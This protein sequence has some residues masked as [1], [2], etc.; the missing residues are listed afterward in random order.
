MNFRS[1]SG[2]FHFF[3]LVYI[4]RVCTVD[5]I[6]NIGDAVSPIVEAVL[7]QGYRISGCAII[8][9]NAVIVYNCIAGFHAFEAFEIFGH[10]DFQVVIAIGYDAEVVF[11]CEFVCV[12][13]PSDDV[14]LFVQFLLDDRSCIAAVLH[15]II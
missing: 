9:R 14:H 7:G 4:D 5:P 2:S 6:S 11:C 1:I 13:N 8:D 12:C 10:A 3:Q 15:A